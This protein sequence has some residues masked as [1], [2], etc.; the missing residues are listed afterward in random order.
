M[1]PTPPPRTALWL[2]ERFASGERHDSLVGDLNERYYRGRSVRWYWRQ[3]L[4]AI[5]VGVLRDIREHKVRA[6][7]AVAIGFSFL[8]LCDYE[9]QKLLHRL[10]LNYFTGAVWINGHLFQPG[11]W[12]LPTWYLSILV[13][14][15]VSGWIVGRLDRAHQVA[16]T[17]LFAACFVVLLTIDDV[18]NGFRRPRAYVLMSSS[19]VLVGILVGGLWGARATDNTRNRIDTQ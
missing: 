4:S 1:T 19:V 9:K 17:C 11:D 7:V 2:L 18:A 3:V 16:M 13:E 6:A 14:G 15:A 10:W 8:L 5:W 12:M